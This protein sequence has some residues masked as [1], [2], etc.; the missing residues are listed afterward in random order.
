[1][2]L[3]CPTCGSKTNELIEC[4]NCGKIGCPR[5]MKKK[6]GKWVCLDCWKEK[7][8]EENVPNIF[9]MFG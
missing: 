1:M 9:S 2:S 8:T 5:C 6:D 3:T 4:E 7:P